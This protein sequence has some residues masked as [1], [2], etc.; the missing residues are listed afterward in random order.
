MIKRNLL[1]RA[2][3]RTDPPW[4]GAAEGQPAW[5]DPVKPVSLS[6][7]S[8][9][10]ISVRAVPDVPV[11]ANG[12]LLKGEAGRFEPAREETVK[13]EMVEEETMKGEMVEAKTMKGE[14]VEEETVKN[15]LA[16]DM[17]ASNKPARCDVATIDLEGCGLTSF[18][19]AKTVKAVHDLAQPSPARNGLMSGDLEG[20][21]LANTKPT[22]IVPA[23]P[24]P[25]KL[26]PEKYGLKPATPAL[27][28]STRPGAVPAVPNAT[29]LNRESDGLASAPTLV[30]GW[31]QRILAWVE[32]QADI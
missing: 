1:K 20:P 31:Q 5:A 28:D 24:D 26:F 12:C 23:L 15:E 3:A 6:L 18:V 10:E 17:P 21:A 8:E 19:P 16:R 25:R 13:E 29:E 4:V 32:E 27:L 9:R 22:V 7:F 30:A 14:M 11:L 2:L